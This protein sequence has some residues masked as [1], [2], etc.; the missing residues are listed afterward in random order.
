MGLGFVILPRI[1]IFGQEITRKEGLRAAKDW[2]NSPQR[3]ARE[4]FGENKRVFDMPTILEFKAQRL[5]KKV[6]GIFK[7][8]SLE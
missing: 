4:S 5:A 8:I 7:N 6:I 2:I 1:F 3:D